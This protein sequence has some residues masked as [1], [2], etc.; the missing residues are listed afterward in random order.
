MY[1]LIGTTM[2]CAMLIIKSQIGALFYSSA[3]LFLGCSLLNSPNN[4]FYQYVPSAWWIVCIIPTP[5]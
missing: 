5:V 2:L 1:K 3:F 4:K